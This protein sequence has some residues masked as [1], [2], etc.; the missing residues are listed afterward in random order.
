M[1]SLI[2]TVI[3]IALVAVLAIATIYYGGDIFKSNGTRAAA[4]KVINNGQ[5][6]NGAIETFK[7]QKGEVPAN[8]EALVTS[9][10][11]SAIPEGTWTMTNDYIVASGVTEGQC[12]EANRQLGRV[13][14]VVPKCSDAEMAGVTA[15]CSTTE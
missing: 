14:T 3:G 4:V 6:I 5:Q 8:L 13:E 7:A 2:L 12:L 11:L 15:C 1:F 9:K 10:Y